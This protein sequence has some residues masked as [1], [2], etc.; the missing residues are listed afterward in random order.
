MTD[1][2]ILHV[3]VVKEMVVISGGRRVS[4]CRS[5]SRCSVQ[6]LLYDM[7]QMFHVD[8]L[9]TAES[10]VFMHE[11]EEQMIQIQILLFTIFNL[12]H[13]L[14]NDKGYSL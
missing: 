7:D 12:Y 13:N 2:V 11:D 1:S 9:H 6:N 8:S 5:A 10:D 3:Y 4:F 14:L